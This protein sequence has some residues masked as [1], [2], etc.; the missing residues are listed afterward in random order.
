MSRSSPA[1][2]SRAGGASAVATLT[3]SALTFLPLAVPA[4]AEAA[5]PIPLETIVVSPNAVPTP[6]AQVASSVTVITAADIRRMQRRTVSQVLR[7]V[8]GLSVVQSGGPG[9]QTA[10]YMRG[11]NANQVKVLIDGVDASDPATPTGAFDFGH[12]LAGDIER[13]EILRGPQ[14]GLYGS[15]A[16]G[17][18]IAITTAKGSGPAKVAG[19]LE[20]GSF[21]TFNQRASL[22]GMSD[23]FDYA[24]SVQHYRADAVPATPPELVPPGR[25]V[26]D[27]S[28]DNFTASTRLGV[29]LTDD[30]STS[31]VARF[32]DAQLA[33]VG[34]DFSVFPAVPAAALS[35]QHN[36]DIY[37]RSQTDWSLLGGRFRNSF[38]A[39]Y[40]DFLTEAAEPG[41]PANTTLGNRLRF[42]WHGALD[43]M[44]GQTLV[45]GAERA[46]DRLNASGTV[47]T[48]GNTAGFVELQSTIG[49]FFMASNLRYDL[50]DAFGGHVT[51]RLAPGVTIPATGTILR[52]S[53]GTG[54]RAPSL[55]Q[56]YVDFPAFNFF[57]N[58]N[59]RPETSVG[60]D[61][62][63]EQPVL[64]GRVVFGATW[65]HIDTRDLITANATF[66]SY[67]NIGSA[68]SEGVE[69]FARFAITEA[70]SLR[71]DYTWT[72]AVDLQTGL[73]LL[74]RPEHKISATLAWTPLQGLDLSAT[75]LHVGSW[76]DGNRD[77]SIPRLNAPGYTTVDLAA[78]YAVNDHAELF[79]RVDNLFNARYQNPT[80]FLAP[81][82]AFYAGL[83]LKN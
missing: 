55:S 21:G 56:L 32:T 81:G 73:E 19:S 52:A 9:G 40:S 41:L 28:Y 78:R 17:G 4:A 67:A 71:T 53:Y 12:L 8:P 63:F 11:A 61:I 3:A 37:L 64:E 62:G 74:R 70:L 39:A 79:G 18:V 80:G 69:A 22:S 47:A 23:R 34:D 13:I 25:P 51:Y 20:G 60:Y 65:F 77:F 42:D 38:G 36:R 49:P 50:N 45:L 54:F 14:S 43:L 7:D 72:R 30:L 15:D 29:R 26:L 83:T 1:A 44:E 33:F 35:T 16:I 6:A 66:T 46:A 58:P 68:R 59:L 82:R 5:S 24:F 10:V 76:V 75:V 57:R 48:G 2:G 31:L 27:N